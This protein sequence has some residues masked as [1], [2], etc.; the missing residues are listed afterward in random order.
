MSSEWTDEEKVWVVK[1]RQLGY[2][3]ILTLLSTGVDVDAGD[4]DMSKVVK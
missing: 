1:F 3:R 2:T 4:G